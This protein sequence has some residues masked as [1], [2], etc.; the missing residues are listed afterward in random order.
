MNIGVRI[1]PLLEKRA[2]TQAKL[3]ETV[4]VTA[5]TMSRWISGSR[6]PK[7]NH[8]LYMADALGVSADYILGRT[9]NE[10]GIGGNN[11]R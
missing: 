1:L 10:Q 2:M 8:L 9:D 3:A 6:V 5:T 4:G 11:I 7:A